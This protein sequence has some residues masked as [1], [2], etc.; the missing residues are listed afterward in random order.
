MAEALAV[1]V[2]VFY[3]AYNQMLVANP[4]VCTALV[5]NS[6]QSVVFQTTIKKLDVVTYCWNMIYTTTFYKIMKS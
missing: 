2:I 6:Q 4:Q 5:E 1:Q 3:E